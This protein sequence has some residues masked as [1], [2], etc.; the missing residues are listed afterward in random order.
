MNLQVGYEGSLKSRRSSGF[1]GLRGLL[2]PGVQGFRVL[3]FGVQGLGFRVL[4]FRVQGLGFV[5]VQA[6][7]KS[8]GSSGLLRVQGF[9]GFGFRVC[10]G[11]LGLQ[12]FR[13]PSTGVYKGSARDLE[14]LGYLG[15]LFRVSG[16]QGFRVQLWP[17]DMWL[18]CGSSDVC[19][20]LL[21]SFA[22]PSY[23]MVWVQMQGPPTS[24]NYLAMKR[25]FFKS[26]NDT[27]YMFSTRNCV[28]QGLI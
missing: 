6:S 9:R 7:L 16:V 21:R 15:F 8:R 2:E 1:R 19:C 14:G 28:I 20:L 22:V 26:W 5:G 24:T 25:C 17:Q 4:G 18:Q 10:Q 11:L 13:D 3:G 12:W 23:T 27:L